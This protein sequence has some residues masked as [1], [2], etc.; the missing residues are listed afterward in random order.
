MFSLDI[1]TAARDE[2][3]D[4]TAR[5]NELVPADMAEG[6]CHLFCVHTTAGLTV[7]ENCDQDVRHDLIRKLDKLIE[8]KSPEFQ[9]F[10]GNSAAHLKASLMGFSLSLPVR[11]DKLLLGCW[12]GVYFCEFDGPR[13]RTVTVQFISNRQGNQ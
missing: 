4:I 6:I 5:L 12:Q 2:M 8:W 11:E 9:H 1:K 7:N 10:E 13:H 3:I